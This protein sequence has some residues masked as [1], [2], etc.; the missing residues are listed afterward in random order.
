[1]GKPKMPKLPP[2]PAPVAEQVDVEIAGQLE[3]SL[4]RRRKGAKESFLTKGHLGSGN[5]NQL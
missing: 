5:K 2:P 3:Q 1:M 4:L